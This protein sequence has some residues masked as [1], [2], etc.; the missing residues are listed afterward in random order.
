MLFGFLFKL[1]VLGLIFFGLSKIPA[2]H[3]VAMLVS[4]LAGVTVLLV[5]KIRSSMRMVAEERRS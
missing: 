4:F 2:L 3:F 5:W 1:T